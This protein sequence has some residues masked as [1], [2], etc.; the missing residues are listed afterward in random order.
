[1]YIVHDEDFDVTLI[2]G[3]YGMIIQ[4]GTSKKEHYYSATSIIIVI[5]TKLIVSQDKSSH[6]LSGANIL[7][8]VLSIHGR[9]N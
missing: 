3:D 9:G 7:E 5:V 8:R 1:M 2:I 6:Y 4:S